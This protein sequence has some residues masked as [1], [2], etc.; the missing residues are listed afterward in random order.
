MSYQQN[1]FS[2]KNN[3]W[4]KN[5]CHLPLNGG[6]KGV[7]FTKTRVMNHIFLTHFNSYQW[8]VKLN[9]TTRKKWL[10]KIL[11]SFKN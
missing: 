1:V 9:K 11:F 8:K 6:F 10:I 5:S 3:I 7:I 4:P 2:I